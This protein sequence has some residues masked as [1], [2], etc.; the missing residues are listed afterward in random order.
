MNR[1][2]SAVHWVSFSLLISFTARSVGGPL[3]CGSVREGCVLKKVWVEIQFKTICWLW[4]VIVVNY[5][6]TFTEPR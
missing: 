3:I 4:S 2:G 5:L 6:V 1:S